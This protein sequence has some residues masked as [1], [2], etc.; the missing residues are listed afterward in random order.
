MEPK[1][2]VFTNRE[3]AVLERPWDIDM[4]KHNRNT[5]NAEIR[6]LKG[7]ADAAYGIDLRKYC[8]YTN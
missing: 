2:P 6:I 3:K 5:T 4:L 7:V 8:L 1:V